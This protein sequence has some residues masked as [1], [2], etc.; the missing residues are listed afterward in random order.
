MRET[1]EAETPASDESDAA[2]PTPPGATATRLETIVAAVSALLLYLGIALLL[3][4][5]TWVDPANR[6]AGGCCD[7]QQFIWFLPWIPTVLERGGGPFFPTQKKA[8][9]R[10][11]P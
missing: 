10:G 7:Q 2:E 5:D 11:K 6:W 8:H 1:S 4:A 3:T 9:P